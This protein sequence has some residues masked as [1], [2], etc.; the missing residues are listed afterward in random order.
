MDKLAKQALKHTEIDI[1]VTL[2]KNEIKGKMK[3]FRHSSL[4]QS[5][6]NIGKHETGQCMLCNQ[7]ETIENVLIKLNKKWQR[8]VETH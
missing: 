7:A 1:Q 4:N 2:S 3:E 5:L 6:F 8:K